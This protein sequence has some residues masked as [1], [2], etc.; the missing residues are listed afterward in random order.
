M[1]PENL[2]QLRGHDSVKAIDDYLLVPEDEESLY[3]WA[4][5]LNNP[6]PFDMYHKRALLLIDSSSS[7]RLK[8]VAIHVQGFV[9]GFNLNL[10]TLGNWDGR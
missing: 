5:I 3:Q 6:Q 9:F 2:P 10:G 7:E 8:Q 1:W 4:R